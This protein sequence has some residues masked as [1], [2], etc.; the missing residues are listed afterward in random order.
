M[1]CDN[2][3]AASPCTSHGRSQ[4]S[5]GGNELGEKLAPLP[6]FLPRLLIWP[7]FCL[8]PEPGLSL[9]VRLLNNTVFFRG[10]FYTAVTHTVQHRL[11]RWLINDELARKWK[12]AGV[13]KSRWLT[14][15]TSVWE[16]R[17]VQNDL[18]TTDPVC[19]G[20]PP[21]YIVIRGLSG[22]N[23][24]SPNYFINWAI[25]GKKKLLNMKCVFFIYNFCLKHF[26]VLGRTRWDIIKNAQK[27]SYR[28]P[29]NLVW[30]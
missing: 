18:R 24:I 28:V 11:I 16:W 21:Y 14:V 15:L 25:F 30:S 3:P 8:P 27:Y 19:E 12:K 6:V 9:V 22:C 7:S 29:V 1:N 26:L 5:I 10:T 20:H 2:V 17:K 4:M 23:K 13:A